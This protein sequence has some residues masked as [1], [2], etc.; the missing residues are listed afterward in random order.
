MSTDVTRLIDRKVYEL[1]REWV[2]EF[3]RSVYSSPGDDDWDYPALLDVTVYLDS[4]LVCRG[5][6]KSESR[7]GGCMDIWFVES[8]NVSTHFCGLEDTTIL[9]RM[10]ADAIRILDGEEIAAGLHT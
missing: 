5:V 6:V 4:G 7:L 3:R 2:V 9:S 8:P 1:D 10:Y